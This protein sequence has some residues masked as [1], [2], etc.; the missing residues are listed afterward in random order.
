VRSESTS[1]L[2]A[3]AVAGLIAVVALVLGTAAGAG[4]NAS[5]RPPLGRYTCYQFDPTSGFLYAGYFT[6][7]TRSTYKLYNGGRGGYAYS[8]ATRKIRWL[9]GPYKQYQYRGEY[10]PKGT[11]GHKSNTIVVLGPEY[12]KLECSTGK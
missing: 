3:T 2:L 11:N 5:V 4:A 6:L 7:L 8:A 12:V 9:S 10:Q 1:R